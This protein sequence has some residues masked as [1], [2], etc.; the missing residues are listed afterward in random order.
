MAE[1]RDDD[2][3]AA[4]YVLG[5]LDAAARHDF[6]Q[7][8]L[9]D[10]ALRALVES[11]E[12][13]LAPLAG[14]AR[15]LPSPDLKRRIEAAIDALQ[16]F[17]TMRGD[18]GSWRTLVPGVERKILHVDREKGYRSFLLRFAPGGVLPPHEHADDE[19]CVMIEGEIVIAGVRL[20]AGD[21]QIAPKGRTHPPITSPRGGIVYIRAPIRRGAT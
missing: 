11:W 14:D 5:T 4:E 21:W 8:L 15:A 6:A 12:R 2:L 9:R 10:R 16:E 20:A 3:D 18:E 17:P 7:R 1:E 13:R 19:E